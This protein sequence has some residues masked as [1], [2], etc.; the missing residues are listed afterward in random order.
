MQLSAIITSYMCDVRQ[1]SAWAN[2][3]LLFA[4]DIAYNVF[5]C[6]HEGAVRTPGDIT[7][8]QRGTHNNT[9]TQSLE[10]FSELH[11]HTNIL[12]AVDTWD[13]EHRFLHAV[14]SDDPLYQYFCL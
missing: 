10:H 3:L 7:L 14:E 6:S 4:C 12:N 5:L 2:F 8:I 1:V 9:V 13:T 11:I